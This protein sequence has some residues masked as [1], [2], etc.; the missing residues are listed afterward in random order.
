[1][2]PTDGSLILAVKAICDTYIEYKVTWNKMDTGEMKLSLRSQLDKTEN[3]GN[4]LH[5]T[6]YGTISVIYY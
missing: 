2:P 1:V 3:L 6:M 5:I 4:E